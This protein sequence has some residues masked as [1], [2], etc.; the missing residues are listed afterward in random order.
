MADVL[1]LAVTSGRNPGS[2]ARTYPSSRFRPGLLFAGFVSLCLP[3]VAQAQD[4]A[5]LRQLIAK[6]AA[7]VEALQQRVAALEAREATPTRTVASAAPASAPPASVA[8]G[9]ESATGKAAGQPISIDWSEGGPNFRLGDGTSFHLRGRLFLD[10]STTGGSRFASRNI[11]GT[12]LSS[13]RLGVDGR[14]G[15]H[16]SY[17]VE[18]EFADGATSLKEN[19]IAYS[20]KLGA[21]DL[22]IYAGNKTGDRSIDGA[23]YDGYVP[24]FQRTMLAT[25]VGPE[26]GIFGVGILGQIIGG[27]WHV[28]ANIVGDDANGNPG[29]ADDTLSYVGRATWTPSIGRLTRLHFG[30]W[31][32]YEA[33]SSGNATIT[34]SIYPGQHF[35]DDARITMTPIAGATSSAGE[36]GEIGLMRGSFWA[37]GEYG[38]RDV[39]A[40]LDDRRWS[41]SVAEAGFFITGEK[42]NFSPRTGAWTEVVPR[43]SFLDKG[44]G[45]I[46]VAA[47]YE[48][49]DLGRSA[50][51]GSGDDTT[52]AVNW[53]PSRN[54]RAIVDWV[55]WNITDPV[56]PY[57]GRDRGDTVNLRLDA[58]F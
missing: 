58:S 46:E 51:A 34:R 45:A 1:E 11:S 49:L 32:Y 47:R 10:A 44:P 41:S 13:A 54:L 36:G 39:R 29:T 5:A 33:I 52:L 21:N 7:L 48:N 24:F 55:H 30:A 43:W 53:F 42:P 28:G 31:G 19:Y 18:L 26:K 40:V 12:E 37:F 22:K 16:W 14:Y 57:I 56:A 38:R 15:E 50:V 23:S 8:L 35:N 27:D 20:T 2:V 3:G 4:D 17:K 9:G 6:Q 25:S